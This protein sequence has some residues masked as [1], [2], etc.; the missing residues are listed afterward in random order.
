[1][2]ARKPLVKSPEQGTDAIERIKVDTYIGMAFSNLV[3]LA[4]M[5]TTAATLHAAGTT[6]IQTSSQA[7]EA[8]KP[9]AGSFAFAIFAMGVVGTG[10]LAIPVLAGSAAYAVGE[11]FKWPIG[12]SRPQAKKSTCFLC[13]DSHRDALWHCDNVVAS[14]PYQSL[15]LECRHQ[16]RGSSTSYGDDDV[17]QLKQTNYGQIR[18]HGY[19]ESCGL[20]RDRNYGCSFYWNGRDINCLKGE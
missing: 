13:H 18:R 3:A 19:F 1:M 15:I 12:L 4:I 14:R 20:A 9:I 16:W 7:A 2:A 6:D 8:L 5:V 10:L 11:A 17:H